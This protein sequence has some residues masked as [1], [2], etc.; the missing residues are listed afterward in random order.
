M[1]L[2]GKV[3][4]SGTLTLRGPSGNLLINLPVTELKESY[5]KTLGW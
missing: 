3:T 2:I 5:K 4:D 1:D